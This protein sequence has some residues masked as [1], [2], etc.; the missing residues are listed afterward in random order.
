VSPRSSTL[1][2]MRFKSTFNDY[3]L[4]CWPCCIGSEFCSGRFDRDRRMGAVNENS[5]AGRYS[6]LRGAAP[7]SQIRSPKGQINIRSIRFALRRLPGLKAHHGP[8][9]Y[10]SF[11]DPLEGYSAKPELTFARHEGSTYL[12]RRDYAPA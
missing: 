4:S 12:K 8:R 9:D 1:V 2:G 10:W 6:R 3:H 7:S 5:S 11:L